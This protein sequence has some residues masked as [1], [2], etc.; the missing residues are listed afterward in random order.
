[1]PWGGFKTGALSLR[2][3]ILLVFISIFRV[4][5]PGAEHALLLDAPPRQGSDLPVVLPPRGWLRRGAAQ[6]GAPRWSFQ[7][8]FAGLRL[9]L[10]ALLY[11]V[12]S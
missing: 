3:G 12:L 2:S 7:L 6:H 11:R 5:A 10:A 9:L 4:G 1:M 8:G